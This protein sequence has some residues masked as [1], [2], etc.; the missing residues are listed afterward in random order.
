MAKRID[1]DLGEEMMMG[2]WPLAGWVLRAFYV[3]AWIWRKSP[4]ES[5]LI[6]FVLGGFLGP[7]M[8]VCFLVDRDRLRRKP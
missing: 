7:L 4:I 1:S 5:L 3:D 2:L 6:V 8:A